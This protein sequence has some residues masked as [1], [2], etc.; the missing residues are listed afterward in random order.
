MCGQAGR[1][2]R[3]ARH[4]LYEREQQS[5]PASFELGGHAVFLSLVFPVSGSKTR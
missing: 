1:Q 3:F 5:D 4:S 2:L